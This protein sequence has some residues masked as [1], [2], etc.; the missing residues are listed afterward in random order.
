MEKAIKDFPNYTIDDNGRVK[1]IH[2]GK[3]LKILT[4]KQTSYYQ[5]SL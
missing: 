3:F 5:V 4:N 1:N 2:T